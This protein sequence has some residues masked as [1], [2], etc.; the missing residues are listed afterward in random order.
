M[1][2]SDFPDSSPPLVIVLSGPSGAGKDAVLDHLKNAAIPFFHV[3]T[4]TTRPI[5]PKEKDGRDYHFTT[6]E[7]FHDTVA[8]GGML[9]YAEVYGNWYGVPKAPVQ[10]ALSQGQDVVIKVDIQGAATI[11]KLIPEAVFIFLTTATVAELK[12]RLQKRK[13]ETTA[14]MELRLKTATREMSAITGFDYVVY[15]PCDGIDQAVNDIAAIIKAEKCRV[16]PRRT[17]V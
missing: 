13:T 9:E 2:G 6:N 14:D 11:K 8:K 10:L 5:R 3:T 7:E 4:L 15:N 1:A 17:T 12:T 16:D